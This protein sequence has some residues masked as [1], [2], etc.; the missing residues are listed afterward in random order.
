LRHLLDFPNI[1]QIATGLG[2]DGVSTFAKRDSQNTFYLAVEYNERA[3][4]SEA[5]DYRGGNEINQETWKKQWTKVKKSSLE[6]V[7]FLEKISKNLKNSSKKISS[8][9]PIL[10]EN[11]SRNKTIFILFQREKTSWTS[12][13]LGWTLGRR[14]FWEY[15][16]KPGNFKFST[17][18][19]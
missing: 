10:V 16:Q 9:F 15:F 17:I 6:G 5:G 8:K 3:G 18:F 11:S 13:V 7:D 2:D 12:F 19:C 1:F 14:I 4:R